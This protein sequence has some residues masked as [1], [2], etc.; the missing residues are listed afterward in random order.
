MTM[1]WILGGSRAHRG[2]GNNPEVLKNKGAPALALL[3]GAEPPVPS[4]ERQESRLGQPP[5]LARD[6]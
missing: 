2:H 3:T 5:V 6:T 4:K 1:F